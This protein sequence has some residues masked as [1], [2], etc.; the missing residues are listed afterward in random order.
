[1]R[2]FEADEPVLPGEIYRPVNL[3][4]AELEV[5][6]SD[7]GRHLFSVRV[8]DPA[9]SSGGYALSPGGGQLAILT[10]DRLALYT[11]PRD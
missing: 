7:N 1:M 11:M 9:A 10:R 6:Q 3:Q 4:T 8:S 2:I 5:Y